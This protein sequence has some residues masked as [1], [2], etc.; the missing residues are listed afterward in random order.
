MLNI[1]THVETWV[2]K[3][4]FIGYLLPNVKSP[5]SGRF[6]RVVSHFSQV[7]CSNGS[8]PTDFDPK[9][10]SESRSYIDDPE[11]DPEQGSYFDDLDP[12]PDY[13]YD[14]PNLDFDD[15]P[16]PDSDD[17]HDPDSEDDPNPEFVSDS[18]PNSDFDSDSDPDPGSDSDSNSY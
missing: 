9:S 5:F 13:N 16:D 17:D 15:D 7:E 2:S 3:T 12:D 6:H 11:P 10:D 1:K 14:N 8:A 18:D 4:L